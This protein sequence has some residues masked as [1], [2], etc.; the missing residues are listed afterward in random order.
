MF[1]NIICCKS[2]CVREREVLT[3]ETDAVKVAYLCMYN[4]FA[5]TKIEMNEES[6]SLGRYRSGP[7]ARCWVLWLFEELVS[8][9]LSRKLWS[10]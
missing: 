7:S 4:I 2:V 8:S 9:P 6:E 10:V 5:E 1:H 3:S